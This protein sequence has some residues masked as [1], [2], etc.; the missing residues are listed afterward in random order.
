M[1]SILSDSLAP[2][3]CPKIHLSSTQSTGD[4]VRS[5]GEGLSPPRLSSA[6]DANHKS[7]WSLV[8]LTDHWL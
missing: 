4:N 5:K 8:L 7:S 1:F 2:A 3:E 6:S